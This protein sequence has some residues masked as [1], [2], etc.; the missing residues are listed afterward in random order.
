[1]RL[2]AFLGQRLAAEN[3]DRPDNPYAE[4]VRTYASGDF[5]ALAHKLETLLDRY[6][7]P[8]SDVEDAYARAMRLELQFFDAASMPLR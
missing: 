7:Q 1:M 6:A 5:E 3:A 8:G 4:W 2:Y